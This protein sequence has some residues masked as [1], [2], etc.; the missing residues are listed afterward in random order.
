[1]SGSAYTENISATYA[2]GVLTVTLPIADRR[3]PIAER[4]KLRQISV[5]VQDQG[6]AITAEQ[7]PAEIAG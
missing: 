6:T 5:A 3:S 7:K 1:L 2:N 4:A